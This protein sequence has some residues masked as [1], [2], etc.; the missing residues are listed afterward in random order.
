MSTYISTVIL[1]D[2]VSPALEDYNPVTRQRHYV[3]RPALL[4][5]CIGG[6][7]ARLGIEFSNG[8]WHEF[9]KEVTD[10]AVVHLRDVIR[11]IEPDDKLWKRLR[12]EW[13]DSDTLIKEAFPYPEVSLHGL[14]YAIECSALSHEGIFHHFAPAASREV[15]HLLRLARLD[16]VRVNPRQ[17]ALYKDNEPVTYIQVTDQG[18]DDGAYNTFSHP[19]MFDEL[20]N[21]SS[22]PLSGTDVATLK[23]W[24]KETAS[25]EQFFDQFTAAV[26]LHQMF[27]VADGAMFNE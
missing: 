23:Q 16:R 3:D 10:D 21:L 20:D 14:V 13:Y 19:V 11:Q 5:L 27:P 4:R 26:K 9:S 22:H 12:H 1:D 2:V 8:T 17:F 7:Y 15:T 18:V 6:G 25:R 24:E